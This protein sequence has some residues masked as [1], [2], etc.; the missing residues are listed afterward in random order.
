VRTQ[1]GTIPY[2]ST[3]ASICGYIN[4]LN[5]TEVS[6]RS[7]FVPR[8]AMHSLLGHYKIDADYAVVKNVDVMPIIRIKKPSILQSCT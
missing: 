6:D 5:I 2:A 7:N 4:F 1:L 3:A 8:V